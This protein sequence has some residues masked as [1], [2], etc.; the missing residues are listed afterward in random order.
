MLDREAYETAVAGLI[1]WAEHVIRS[2]R[3]AG[4]AKSTREA[5]AVALAVPE[6][7]VLH[8][9]AASVRESNEFAKDVEATRGAAALVL[10][11]EV[12]PDEYPASA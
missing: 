12:I 4:C 8:P 2:T 9:W 6:L 11:P 5:A 10:N 7:A 3:S 1:H